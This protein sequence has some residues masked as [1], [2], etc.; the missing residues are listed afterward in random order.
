MRL[1][2]PARPR[3]SGGRG[4][5][6]GGLIGC[7]V[8]MPPTMM[9]LRERFLQHPLLPPRGPNSA[10]RSP[11]RPGVSCTIFNELTAPSYPRAI[12]STS[13]LT[14]APAFATNLAARG[15]NSV[16]ECNLAKVDVES[17]NLFSRSIVG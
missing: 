15:S 6:S 10:S 7:C 11:H 2:T 13:S 5:R 12:S 4:Q 16:V 8:G 9:T 1:G 17:S 3:G 14:P